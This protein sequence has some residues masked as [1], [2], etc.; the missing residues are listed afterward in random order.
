VKRQVS[1]EHPRGRR[2]TRRTGGPRRSWRIRASALLQV[3]WPCGD[4]GYTPYESRRRGRVSWEKSWDELILDAW[5]DH[6]E[7]RKGT[8]KRQGT[9][10]RKTETGERRK[11]GR[12]LKQSEKLSSQNILL[13]SVLVLYL[14]CTVTAQPLFTLQ[15]RSLDTVDADT[16][17][18]EL[19]CPVCTSIHYCRRPVSTSMPR[20]PLVG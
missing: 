16:V 7:R 19:S 14:C 6:F 4:V 9:G 11:R 18:N 8:S 12:Q 5:G 17:A 2:A 10:G 13:Y 15:E 20:C 3:Q 1:S